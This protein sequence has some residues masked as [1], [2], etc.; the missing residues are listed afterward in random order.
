MFLLRCARLKY[1]GKLKSIFIF[2]IA[3]D[4]SAGICSLFYNSIDW[5]TKN[6]IRIIYDVKP[7]SL[8]KY[9]TG[10]ALAQY[11]NQLFYE[12]PD[13]QAIYFADFYDTKDNFSFFSKIHPDIPYYQIVNDDDLLDYDCILYKFVRKEN[14]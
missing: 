5:Y 2:T 10:Q 8:V 3:A 7:V 9:G 13:V 1:K 4:T 12:Y 14:A 6:E 11:L